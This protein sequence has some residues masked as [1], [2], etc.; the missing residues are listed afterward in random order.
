MQ[1]VTTYGQDRSRDK[2]VGSISGEPYKLIKIFR[3]DQYRSMEVSPATTAA[4]VCDIMK[5][6]FGLQDD[7]DEYFLFDKREISNLINFVV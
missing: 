7:E 5:T 2:R 6:K 3:K 1:Y 4:E